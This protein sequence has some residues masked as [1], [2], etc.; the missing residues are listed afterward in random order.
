MD[1][2]VDIGKKGKKTLDTELKIY[3]NIKGMRSWRNWHTRKTK[4]LV[5]ITLVGV[6]VPPTAPKKLTRFSTKAVA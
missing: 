5:S 2:I 3:Y 1:I 6:Q 4:D